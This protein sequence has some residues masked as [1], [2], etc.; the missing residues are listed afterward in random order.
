MMWN[1][2]RIDSIYLIDLIVDL[3]QSKFNQK[4]MKS[5][6]IEIKTNQN[7]QIKKIVQTFQSIWIWKCS[8]FDWKTTGQTIFTQ[9]N[10]ESGLKIMSKMN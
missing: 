4:Q 3:I 8:N 1:S 7:C 9:S 10:R 5:N 2:I 6:Q